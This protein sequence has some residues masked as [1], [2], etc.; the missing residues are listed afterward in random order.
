MEFITRTRSVRAPTTPRLL[1]SRRRF[2]FER[3]NTPHLLRLNFGLAGVKARTA[4]IVDGY[5][6]HT[7]RFE[8]P[9]GAWS[10][11]G[12]EPG[13]LIGVSGDP[14]LLKV[15]LLRNA[16]LN[17]SFSTTRPRD[18]GIERPQAY[19]GNSLDTVRQ[20]NRELSLAT[21]KSIQHLVDRIKSLLPDLALRDR[22]RLSRGLFDF[23]GDASS[24]LFGT[25]TASDIDGLRQEV[26][27]IKDWAG[28]A[29][30]DNERTREGLATF[31]RLSNQRFDAMREVLDRE[32]K[33]LEI[34]HKEAQSATNEM[35]LLD[36]MISFSLRELASYVSL[37]DSI[38][39][40]ELG[41]EDLIRGQLTPRMISS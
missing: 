6:T 33:A 28:T 40:L 13:T 4:C 19:T 32:Q 16:T 8:L 37:H 36:M 23:V 24:Y 5:W 39:E 1:D 10:D 2:D 25:A 34:L 12:N 35:H 20:A 3:V 38:Q 15:T 27:K 9:V 31:T 29:K 7:F 18:T 14:K 41:M 11:L 30:V 22:R 17:T 21:L 26:R